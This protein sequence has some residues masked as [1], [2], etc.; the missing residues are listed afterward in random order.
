[1]AKKT[2]RSLSIDPELQDLVVKHAAHKGQ[3]VSQFICNWLKQYPY[4]SA[5]VIP[6]VVDVP[7]EISDNK[8]KLTEF[9]TQKGNAIVEAFT[10]P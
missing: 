4:G 5:D 2:I 1:M 8:E 7:R 9:F 3:S 6:V 10:S